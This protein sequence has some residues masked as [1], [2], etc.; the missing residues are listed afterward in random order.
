MERCETML[1]QLI[2]MERITLSARWARV[3]IIIS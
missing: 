3:Y 1:F 2:G